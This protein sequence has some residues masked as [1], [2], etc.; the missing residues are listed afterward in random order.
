M[1]KKDRSRQL[2]VWNNRKVF[3]GAV[4]TNK[5]SLLQILHQDQ[6]DSALNEKVKCNFC[7]DVSKYSVM[8]RNK[9][10]YVSFSKAGLLM[11][12]LRII[13]NSGLRLWLTSILIQGKIQNWKR[14]KTLNINYFS[15][16]LKGFESLLRRFSQQGNEQREL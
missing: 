1:M 12:C 9:A 6:R 4:K 7:F 10:C 16:V 5:L 14:E 2:S 15:K 3:R 8:C 13:W 11:N